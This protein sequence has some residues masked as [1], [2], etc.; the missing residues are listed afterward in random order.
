MRHPAFTILIPVNSALAALLVW[1]WV[2]PD[3]T[4]KNTAWMPPE[5]QKT[6][7]VQMLPSL[8]S[9]GQVDT[10]KF[11]AMLD[12][13][14]FMLTRRPPPPPPPTDAPAPVDALSTARIFGVFSSSAGGGVIMNLG[15]KDRRVRLNEAIEGGW[16]LQSISKNTVT[17]AAGEQSRSLTLPRA[18]LT[19]Y[20][21][22]LPASPAPAV[23]PSA[24]VQP[25][26]AQPPGSAEAASTPASAPAP[27]PRRRLRA[28]FGGR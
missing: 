1:L 8:P 27:I 5:A 4:L 22:L 21:G 11:V 13:P 9:T 26:A 19:T 3:G 24:Q 10:S 18:A 7:Y 23:P 20:S 12:R 14:L 16:T 25:A 15:G 28:T 2:T 6:D 17:F